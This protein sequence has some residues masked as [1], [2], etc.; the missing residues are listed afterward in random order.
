M[1]RPGAWNVTFFRAWAAQDTGGGPRC[2]RSGSG[3]CQRYR[4]RRL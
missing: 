1:D 2:H 3:I 4:R